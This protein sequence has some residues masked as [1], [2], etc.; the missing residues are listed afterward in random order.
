[1]PVKLK[2]L[3]TKRGMSLDQL[4]EKLGIPAT[5]ISKYERGWEAIPTVVLRDLA[6]LFECDVDHVLGKETEATEW[7]ECEW[8]IISAEEPYGG[9]EVFAAGQ[10]FEYPI[11]LTERERILTLMHEM[12]ALNDRSSPGHLHFDAMNNRSVFLNL[13]HVRRLTLSSDDERMTPYYA[14]PEV[15]LAVDQN[16]ERQTIFGP[17]LTKALAEHYEAVGGEETAEAEV[18]Q[19]TCVFADGTR[20]PD[21][22]LYDEW[23]GSSLMAF[24]LAVPGISPGSFVRLECE[25]YHQEGFYN[26]DHIAVLEVPTDEYRRLTAPE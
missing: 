23:V 26:L 8:A 24:E 16:K 6:V 9:L 4:A 14:H 15:Y 20:E 22:H 3:R 19:I 13:A 5:Q 2:S 25:G 11:S 18:E 17:V 12:D 10:E 1:M 7:K 21:M